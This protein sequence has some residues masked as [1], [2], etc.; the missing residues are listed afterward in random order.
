MEPTASTAASKPGDTFL[1]SLSDSGLFQP[2]ELGRIVKAVPASQRGDART[3]AA[4]LIK[5]RKLTRFQAGM[6]L[7]GK[8][9]GLLLGDYLLLDE[10]GRGGMG[11]V[12][13]ARDRRANR[14]VAL[15]VLSAGVSVAPTALKRFRREA[16]AA[17]KLKHPHVVAAL[18]AGEANG[19]HFL[20]MEYV[21]GCDLAQQVKKQGPVPVADAV[22][23]ILQAAR[24]LAHA[25]E[26]GIIHRDIK[27]S[28]VILTQAKEAPSVGVVKILDLGLARMDAGA[29]RGNE[30]VT[31]GLTN[32][33]SLMGT[34]DYMAPEQAMNAKA[35]DHRA[36]IYSLGCTL[37]FLVAGK[38]MYDGETAMEKVF[39]HREKPIPALPGAPRR[40][41]AVFARMVAKKPEDRHPSMAEVIADLEKCAA[42]PARR[43]GRLLVGLVVG[44]VA[45]AGV[46][47]ALTLGGVT[48]AP[49]TTQSPPV[50][51]S[52]APPPRQLDK[53]A[54]QPKVT[55]PYLVQSPAT[56]PGGGGLTINQRPA[57]RLPADKAGEEKWIAA[58]APKPGPGNPGLGNPAPQEVRDAEA[59]LRILERQK[60]LE[61]QLPLKR[62]APDPHPQAPAPNPP[63]PP[64]KLAG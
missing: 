2:A 3:F 43:K 29:S 25:H 59:L 12:Y 13:R 28:N 58:P 54:A 63:P 24:G 4:E 38:P 7:Q 44:S 61:K 11:A 8:A 52:P 47:F 14:L 31:E 22:A 9:R 48:K 62:P 34:C 1:Q 56:A 35:A 32:T 33:G 41:Q 16:R 17:A 55:S 49:P 64:G 46:I 42:P 10:L 26:A 15:K 37:Y 23:Y 20:V 39:A 40:L 53:L 6:L 18:D 50:V 19:V 30:T 60:A 27:P 36:D 21:D 45:A 5:Q 51:A 57:M